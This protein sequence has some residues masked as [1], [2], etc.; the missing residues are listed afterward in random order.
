MVSAGSPSR[1]HPTPTTPLLEQSSSE[2]STLNCFQEVLKKSAAAAHDLI[3]VEVDG[4]H[5]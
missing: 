1:P 2:F 3:L 5:P 4:K